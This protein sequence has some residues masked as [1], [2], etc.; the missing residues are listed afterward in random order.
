MNFARVS[1]DWLRLLRGKRS[2]RGFSKR[3]G[4][5]S[6]IAYRWESGACFPLARQVYALA[7][8]EGAA[9]RVAL[10]SFFGG[11]LPGQL[12]NVDLSTR[13]GVAQMLRALRMPRARHWFKTPKAR[14][15]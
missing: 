9:G 15:R 12:A 7:K 6:N 3:L 11:E 10:T 2:Q 1:A 8:R 14:G 4:Y 13:A 5:A